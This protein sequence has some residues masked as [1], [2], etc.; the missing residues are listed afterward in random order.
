MKYLFSACLDTGGTICQ[1]VL[2]GSRIALLIGSSTLLELEL[3]TMFC[4]LCRASWISSREICG[5]SATLLSK[6]WKALGSS[7]YGWSH[8]L[9][10]EEQQ[11]VGVGWRPWSLTESNSRGCSY[12]LQ[13]NIQVLT[14][15]NFPWSQGPLHEVSLEQELPQLFCPSWRRLADTAPG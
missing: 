6:F 7:G 11:P 9:F 1:S 13:A 14:I 4:S 10:R 3:H 8:H 15:R 12:L 2:V 5:V